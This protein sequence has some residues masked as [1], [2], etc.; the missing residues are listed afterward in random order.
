MKTTKQMQRRPFIKS[1]VGAVGLVGFVNDYGP[2]TGSAAETSTW[3][4]D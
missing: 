3:G 1:A 2:A 4:P